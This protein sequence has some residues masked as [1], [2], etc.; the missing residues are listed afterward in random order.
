MIR[1]HH[2]SRS[3]EVLRNVYDNVDHRYGNDV[4][5]AGDIVLFKFPN[6]FFLSLFYVYTYNVLKD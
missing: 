3:F 6:N 5:T 2:G 4:I 1:L